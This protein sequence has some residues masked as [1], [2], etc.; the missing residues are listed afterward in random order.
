MVDL[1]IT[2]LSMGLNGYKAVL[3]QRIRLLELFRESLERVASVFGER[4]LNCPRNTISFG[5][6]LDNLTKLENKDVNTDNLMSS[7]ET[8]AAAADDDDAK[9]QQQELNSQ[10]TKFGSMLFTRCISGTRVVPRGSTNTISG[11]S[12]HGFG[13]SNDN[14]PYAYMT[15]ACAV[16]MGEE[17]MNDFFVRLERAWVD[18]RS[19]MKKRQSK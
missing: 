13:S 4:V 3:E 9:K 15:A 5:M 18:Y 14:Y 17:E 6:T 7:H 12:F 10:I 16:G 11:H 1:F 2:L 8:P 19:N